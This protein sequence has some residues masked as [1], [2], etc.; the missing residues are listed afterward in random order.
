MHFFSF[1]VLF[2]KH[3]VEAEIYERKV[4]LEQMMVYAVVVLVG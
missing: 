4:V 2:S 3:N 1:S